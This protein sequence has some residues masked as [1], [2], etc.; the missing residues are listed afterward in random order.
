M[1]WT[2]E[3]AFRTG[4]PTLHAILLEDGSYTLGTDLD[5]AVLLEL[6]TTQGYSR[7]TASFS[8]PVQNASVGGVLAPNVDV[9]F[10]RGSTPN[11]ILQYDAVALI[12]DGAAIANTEVTTISGSPST[13]TTTAA[14]GHAAGDRVL[15]SADGLPTG[16]TAGTPYFVLSS[17]LTTTEFQ[18]ATVAGGTAIAAGESWTGTLTCHHAKGSLIGVQ[19]NVA[20][21]GSTTRDWNPATDLS[22]RIKLG[23]RGAAV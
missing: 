11:V 9:T 12:A 7:Q 20:I 21:N 1:G 2:F 15:F 6:L 13:F 4:N 23:A 17:G 10:S 3:R 22:L 5:D 14:H 16:L 19:R 8:E 18:V